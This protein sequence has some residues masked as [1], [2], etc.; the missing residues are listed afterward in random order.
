M[1]DFLK[2][3]GLTENNKGTSTGRKAFDASNFDIASHSPVDGKLIG[4]VS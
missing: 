4:N 2:N 3:L 1:K